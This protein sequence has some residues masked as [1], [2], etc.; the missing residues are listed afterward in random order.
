MADDS[1]FASHAPLHPRQKM[2]QLCSRL[3]ANDKTLTCVDLRDQQF[4][5]QNLAVALAS[6]TCVQELILL[7]TCCY[8]SLNDTTKL[9]EGIRLNTSLMTLNLSENPLGMYGARC[10]QE[11]LS[12]HA[13]L[14]RLLLNRSRLCNDGIQLLAVSPLARLK[15]LEITHNSLGPSSGPFL[16]SLLQSNPSLSRL[17]VSWNRLLGDGCCEF[18]SAGLQSLQTLKLIGNDIGLRGAEAIGEAIAVSSSLVELCL[19]SNK[20]GDDGVIFLARGLATNSSLRKLYLR[21]NGIGDRGIVE[22]ARALEYHPLQYLALGRN[23]IGDVGAIELLTQS[24]NCRRQLHLQRN[25]ITSSGGQ[26]L[27]KAL[28]ES[29]DV[30]LDLLDVHFNNV[31]GRTCRE[32]RF[33]TNLHAAGRRVLS[34]DDFSLSL[35][36]ALLNRVVGDQ[37]SIIHFFLCQ[38]PELC[39]LARNENE[40]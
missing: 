29:T 5:F 19:G 13:S 34:D 6:N 8:H 15:V 12:N 1:D 7:N 36:P 38:R 14:E 18:L 30:G 25:R 10:V 40:A 9:L 20:L 24:R 35:W 32:I 17:D 26:I 39:S 27:V 37:P 33:W 22:L 2:D 23:L 11:A 16:R 3:A 4:D 21:D 31:E 28:R